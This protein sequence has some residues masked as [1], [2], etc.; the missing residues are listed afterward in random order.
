MNP[1]LDASRRIG[2]L[3]RSSARIAAWVFGTPFATASPKSVVDQ[4][5]QP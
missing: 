3:N 2:A 4:P 5:L 1:L